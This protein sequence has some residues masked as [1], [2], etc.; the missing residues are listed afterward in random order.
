MGDRS[1][2]FRDS[3]VYSSDPLDIDNIQHL[4]HRQA[5][6]LVERGAVNAK[7]S[8]GGMADIEYYVQA[9]QIACGGKDRSVRLTNTLS[10]LDAL[11]IRRLPRWRP[12]PENWG[13]V[14]IPVGTGGRSSRGQGKR[15][16]PEHPRSGDQRVLPP[17]APAVSRSA[18]AAEPST[19][20]STWRRPGVYGMSFV[21]RDSL[22]S[23]P[24]DRP[25]GHQRQ[26]GDS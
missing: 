23:S 8:S 2:S 4:R 3:F 12:R 9:W 21:P 25:V 1:C 10:A 20:R 24:A 13:V 5:V 6:E 19:S 15:L 17:G 22:E 11:Q 18:R 16:G 7:I 14:Q 26:R